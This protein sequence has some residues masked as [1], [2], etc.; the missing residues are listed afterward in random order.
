M[1]NVLAIVPDPS[2]K[3][4]AE[5]L[6]SLSAALQVKDHVAIVRYCRSEDSSPKLAVLSSNTKGYL[7]FNQIPFAD[8][9]R[10]WTFR[11]F[12]FLANEE[13]NSKSGFTSKCLPLKRRLD[14]VSS[15]RK[16]TLDARKVSKTKAMEAIHELIDCLD[17]SGEFERLWP[18]KTGNVSLEKVYNGIMKKTMGNGFQGFGEN[19]IFFPAEKSSMLDSI[20]RNLQNVFDL[21][22][23]P[24]KV[25]RGR[26]RKVEPSFDINV[27]EN[28]IEFSFLDEDTS[29][30][31]EVKIETFIIKHFYLFSP[32]FHHQ[33][34]HHLNHRLIHH[35]PHYQ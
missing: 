19:D 1:E 20:C 18:K 23:V 21:S 22:I 24:E 5:K 11:P 30:T 34:S 6:A 25:H 4:A 14:Q 29:T 17:C 12:D 35:Q 10:Q 28:E 33:S 2:S 31:P 13:V 26:I 27:Q 7:Y 15:A 9:I 8:D 32:N 3:V 16:H